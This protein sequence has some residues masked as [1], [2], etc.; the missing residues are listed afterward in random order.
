MVDV[1]E[2]LSLVNGT[3]IMKPCLGEKLLNLLNSAKV[4][5]EL[6]NVGSKGGGRLLFATA[7]VGEDQ[8]PTFAKG[9]VQDPKQQRL[10]V[11][12]KED[13][14]TVNEVEG[15]REPVGKDIT[16]VHGHL[17]A[18]VIC[19][20]SSSCLIHHIVGKVDAKDGR[21]VLGSHEEG[22]TAKP[23]ANIQNTMILG[24]GK[25]PEDLFRGLLTT[26]AN[27]VTTI[28]GLIGLL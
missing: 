19:V 4:I 22:R 14:A 17:T 16:M 24:P 6:P 13:L 3:H 2:L 26:G 7:I 5:A 9:A 21:L 15:V 8:P 11:D 1:D 25:A 28:D 23:T 20:T 18:K 10:V 12:V 27:K